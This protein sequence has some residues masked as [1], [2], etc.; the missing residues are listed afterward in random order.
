[1][2]PKLKGNHCFINLTEHQLT[3]NCI[4]YNAGFKIFRHGTI[5]TIHARWIVLIVFLR[6]IKFNG[7]RCFVFLT[8]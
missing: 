8:G 7:F 1:M 3:L 4:N 5:Y 6:S 2:A